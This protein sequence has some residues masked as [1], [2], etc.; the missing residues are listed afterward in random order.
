[1]LQGH[2]LK[3]WRLIKEPS[4]EPSTRKQSDPFSDSTFLR[5]LPACTYSRWDM[6]IL[7]RG[8]PAAHGAKA[9]SEQLHL[10]SALPLTVLCS[11]LVPIGPHRANQGKAMPK[12]VHPIKGTAAHAPT[13]AV[14]S[15]TSHTYSAAH[16]IWQSRVLGC[17]PL[18]IHPSASPSARLSETLP[19][20]MLSNS[21]ER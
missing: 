6:I 16:A 9:P 20:R 3:S 14:G 1:M 19:V 10:P 11:H 18:F 7:Q 13:I 4:G 17:V 8:L 21:M 12:H 15:V 5:L 2:I